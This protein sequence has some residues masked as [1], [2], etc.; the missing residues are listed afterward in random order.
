VD[1]TDEVEP[2]AP[3]ETGTTTATAPLDADQDGFCAAP[4]GEDAD[5]CDDTNAAINPNATEICNGIDDNCD[6]RFGRFENDA[7]ENG[8]PDCQDGDFTD[9]ND[10]LN[11]STSSPAQ[12]AALL[13]AMALVRRRRRS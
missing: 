1:V 2:P 5:D 11:C 12:L 8:T 9:D 13:G 4:D 3:N 6:G 7:N 10:L